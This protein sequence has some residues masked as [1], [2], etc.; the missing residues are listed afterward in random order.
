MTYRSSGLGLPA[1]LSS[2]SKSMAVLS[3]PLS[4]TWRT[5]RV[6]SVFALNLQA[7][8]SNALFPSQMFAD[9]HCTLSLHWLP[10]PCSCQDLQ[11]AQLVFWLFSQTLIQCSSI[12]LLKRKIKK[13][14]CLT[15]VCYFTNSTFTGLSL[16]R[17]R[18]FRK[19]LSLWL[20]TPLLLWSERSLTRSFKATSKKGTSSWAKERPYWST[21]QGSFQS[22]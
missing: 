4:L 14:S 20:L 2:N 9:L 21:W 13:S 19:E 3:P 22:Q 15:L 10:P 5:T 18:S 11:L 16:W 12:F 1:F 17:K 8:C 7:V 6:L